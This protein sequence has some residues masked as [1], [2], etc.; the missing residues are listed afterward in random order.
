M[1][2]AAAE[3]LPVSIRLREVSLSI[4][5]RPVLAA[6]DAEAQG[7]TITAIVGPNAVG[8]TTLLRAIAGLLPPR[9]GR[10]E[11]RRG[12]RLLEPHRLSPR[13]RA[14]HLAYL[15]QQIRLPAGFAVEEIVAMGRYA[16]P[17]DPRR[18]DAAIAR[19]RLDELRQRA[20]HTLSAGQQ[21]RTAIARA[22]AQLGAGGVLLLDEPFAAL[23]LRASHALAEV[24][25]GVAAEGAA[26]LVSIHDLL[27]ARRLAGHAWMLEAEGLCAA[28]PLAEVLRPDRLERLFGPAAAWV[29]AEA[30]V[31]T[32]GPCPDPASGS[33]S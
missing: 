2:G 14:S 6:V 4:G 3:A 8:K 19:L 9:Q 10:I 11:L 18:V 16:L 27:L 31:P 23:D 17:E 30:G 29:A 20:V 12:E 13:L 5:A 28:G 7:G 21:Q 1:S 15:P 22:L 26:V 24:L 32:M 25:A 33:S